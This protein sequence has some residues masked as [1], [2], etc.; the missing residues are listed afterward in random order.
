MYTN[1]IINSAITLAFSG[2]ETFPLRQMW[3]KKVVDMADA[4]GLIKK[5]K[6]N[7]AEFIAE[8]GVGKNMLASMKHWAQACQII[9][10]HD[11]SSF[12]LTELAKKNLS[13]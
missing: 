7:S 8:L 4:N 3:I 2:H 1:Q 6:F 13:A 11:L 10:E 12:A 5:A 9:T